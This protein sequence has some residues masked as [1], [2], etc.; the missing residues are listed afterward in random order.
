MY[1]LLTLRPDSHSVVTRAAKLD[2]RSVRI[3]LCHPRTTLLSPNCCYSIC[4]D[5]LA[6]WER[7][8]CV[9]GLRLV[10]MFQKA[11]HHQ[12]PTCT[13]VCVGKLTATR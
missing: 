6:S 9:I 13:Y 7:I 3:V 10:S 4:R 8:R 12:D 5:A 11:D 1:L 2:S